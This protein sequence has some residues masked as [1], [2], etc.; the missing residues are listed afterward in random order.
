MTIIQAIRSALFYVAF[1]GQTIVLALFLGTIAVITGRS[2]RMPDW[3]INIGK[4]W[5]ASNL[6]FLRVFCGIRSEISGTENIP[7]GGC[8]I[9]SKHQSDWDIFAIL[10][11]SG[12][13]AFIA[14]KELLDIPF[15]G[16][17][18]KALNCIP[19]DRKKGGQAVPAMTAEAKSA[20]AR[21]CRIII[22]PEGTRKA[23]LAPPDYRYGASRLY[24]AL[25]VPVV[26]VALNSGLFW[27]RNNLVLWPG[28]ARAKFLPPIPPGLSTE[29]FQSRLVAAIEGETNALILEAAKEGLSRPLTPELRQ[30]LAALQQAAQA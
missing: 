1:I 22:F 12:T 2:G 25:N 13:P 26:P 10:P 17:A 3:G 6:T 23:P 7:E 8:L 16:W 30:K 20:I 21:G 4:Y 9:V 29:E 18:M 27:G 24:A 15:L 14:K 19:V 28:I 11:H 5:G